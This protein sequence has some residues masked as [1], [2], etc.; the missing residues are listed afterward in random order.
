[1][2]EM[3]ISIKDLGVFLLFLALMTALVYLVIALKRLADVLGGVN[4]VISANEEVVGELLRPVPRITS[5]AAEISDSVMKSVKSIDSSIATVGSGI[6][7]TVAAVQESAS[8]IGTYISIA[9]E[10]A[11]V[12]M[13]LMSGSKKKKKK[14]WGR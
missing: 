7:Q 2:L 5:N 14:R 10:I 3:A 12:V 9:S 1:M 11:R 6:T 4:R 8:D 13:G